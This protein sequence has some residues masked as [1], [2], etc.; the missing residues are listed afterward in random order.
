[1][2][3]QQYANLLF[4]RDTV[5]PWMEQHPE[6]VQFN[7]FTSVCGTYGCVL[8][9]YAMHRH[10]LAGTDVERWCQLQHNIS[11]RR[12]DGVPE[13]GIGDEFYASPSA[14]L[15]GGAEAGTLADRKARL[16]AI[17]A[18]HAPKFE[19]KSALPFEQMMAKLKAG[20]L[21]AVA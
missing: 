4:L 12:S 21:E 19:K 6:R 18:E 7:D 2:N 20:E 8:G 13:F 10:G 9:W 3:A 14:P 17:I 5:I 1:M 16:N 15:F 11:T